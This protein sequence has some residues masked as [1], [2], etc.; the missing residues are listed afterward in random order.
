MV[1]DCVQFIF[2]EG[3]FERIWERISARKEHYMKA[4]MLR[5]QF[6][7]LEPPQSDEAMIV[8]ISPDV[9][10]IMKN[11]LAAIS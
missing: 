4:E 10:T 8:D 6:A 9:Q 1:A 3:S 5:S 2:L 11:I 7:A